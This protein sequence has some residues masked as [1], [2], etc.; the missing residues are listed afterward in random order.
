MSPFSTGW[1]CPLKNNSPAKLII[2]HL[3]TSN[4][5]SP[6][7][8]LPI[9]YFYIGKLLIEFCI[10]IVVQKKPRNRREEEKLLHLSE[11]YI[12][13]FSSVSTTGSLCVIV[14]HSATGPSS[15]RRRGIAL[16]EKKKFYRYCSLLLGIIAMCL[17]SCCGLP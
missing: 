15:R 6:P 16:K 14:K 17:D 7:L 4:S 1:N 5:L 12:T 13:E 11:Q 9:L 3:I 8:V 2:N 10:P